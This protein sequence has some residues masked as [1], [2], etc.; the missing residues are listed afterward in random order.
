M[1][2]RLNDSI[3]NKTNNGT[4]SVTDTVLDNRYKIIRVIGEGGF[5]ITYE[6]VNLHNGQRTAIKEHKEGKNEILLKEARLLRDFAEEP[7]IVSVLDSFTENDKT[8]MVMEYLDGITLSNEI[9]K[10]GKWSTEK[11]VRTF[12]PLMD[13]LTKMHKAGVIH[14]DISPDNLMYMPDGSL[15]LMDFGAAKEI[16][17]NNYTRTSIYKSVYSPPEQRETGVT[18]GPYSD[19]YALCATIYYCITERE[20]EDS[21]SRL[22]FDE[23]K[24]P[25]ETGADILPGAEKILLKGLE[26]NCEDR[27]QDI[28]DL[29]NE[30]ETVYP[31][32]SEEEKLKALQR[33]QRRKRILLGIMFTV[34]ICLAALAYT[35]RV[36]I[37][38]LST[39]TQKFMLNGNSLSK[40]EFRAQADGV[41]ERIQA[42]AGKDNF[43]WKE[44]QQRIKVEIPSALFLSVDPLSFI[45]TN[46]T[47]PNILSVD[48]PDEQLDLGIFSQKEDI[49]SVQKVSRG[50][51]LTFSD[52]AAKRF[53]NILN[54]T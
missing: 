10:N 15:V 9:R 26:L 22:L 33:K 4:P 37:R 1:V 8:Y 5:G 25:S 28:S 40:D 13:A 43:L 39:E 2:P 12:A 24:K 31:D 48:I 6:A 51:L 47:R 11:T 30:L 3:S 32:L 17:E 20:P 50:L 19:I 29:K 35:Y 44:E 38:F 36:R 49:L 7:S 27:I 53:G 41:K 34:I 42:F 52:E 46:L 21:L 23:L 18:L 45:R 16:H 14:R 54:E